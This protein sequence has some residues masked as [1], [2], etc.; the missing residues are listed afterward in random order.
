[1]TITIKVSEDIFPVRG[2]FRISRGARTETRVVTV[3]VKYNGL[4]GRGECVPY[5][6]YGETTESVIADIQRGGLALSEGATR[7]DIQ[8]IMQPGAARN[9]IDCALWDLEAK[10]AGKRAWE[11]AGIP[12]PHINETAFTLS[13][14]DPVAMGIAAKEANDRPLLKIKLAGKDDIERVTNIRTNAPNARLI[15]DANEGWT[16]DMVLPFSKK[17]AELGVSMIEQP[18]PASDDAALAEIPHAVPLCADESAH[19]SADIEKLK[20]RYEIVN[21]KL[22]KTGGLTEAIKFRDAIISAGMDV[23]VG[24]MLGTSLGMAPAMLIAQNAAFVDLD[25]PLLLAEDRSPGL[26]YTES[27]IAPP[28]SELWG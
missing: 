17:L 14:D 1:M 19:T 13:L 27:K 25:G 3:T 9:A 2:V 6:H 5:S 21:I 15:V 7:S 8:T 4:I 20:G 11:I 23:M 28:A 26:C 12:E 18:L 16:P 10:K 22:D 24:C